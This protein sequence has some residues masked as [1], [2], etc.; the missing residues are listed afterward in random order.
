MRVA[1]GRGQRHRQGPPR[2]AHHLQQRFRLVVEVGP[3]GDH[4][5]H[6][7]IDLAQRTGDADELFARR[8][9]R[10]CRL[11]LAR[12]VVQRARG[13]EPEC[14]GADPFR[15]DAA[16]LRDLLGRRG[17][18]IC[19]AL[20]HHEQAQRPVAHLRGEVDVVRTALERVE[21]VGDALPVPGQA[22]VQRGAGDVLHALHELDELRVV[23]GV[24][25][26][27]P[28]AAVAHHDRRHAMADEG[29]SCG[30]QVA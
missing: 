9:E 1:P 2:H 23:G 19:T 15:R 13:G 24:D 3:I 20:S 28:D 27:E 6:A 21:V 26:S 16:H 4:L 18:A 30:S 10:R 14:A 17:L 8:S 25:R 7:G 12:A 29:W 5:H 11:A 22:F